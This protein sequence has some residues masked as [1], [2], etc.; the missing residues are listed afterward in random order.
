MVQFQRILNGQNSWNWSYLKRNVWRINNEK[1]ETSLLS[2]Q[3]HWTYKFKQYFSAK[4]ALKWPINFQR[5][6]FSSWSHF[7][8]PISLQLNHKAPY[9]W[10]YQKKSFLRTRTP[11]HV[12]ISLL[13]FK[14]QACKLWGETNMKSAFPIC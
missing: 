14:L 13:L 9:K 4:D 12:E 6:T 5:W 7:K 8:I 3:L 11:K 1:L 2:K 10:K